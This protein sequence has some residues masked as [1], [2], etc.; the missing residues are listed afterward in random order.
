V[1]EAEFQEPVVNVLRV[2]FEDASTCEVEEAARD[3]ARHR[4]ERFGDGQPENDQGREDRHPGRQRR[5]AAERE[6][7]EAET[8]GGRARVA[9][10]RA[11]RVEV[12]REE[13]EE[14]AAENERDE[15]DV[16]LPDEHGD[17][18]ETDRGAVSY[19]HLTLPTIYSV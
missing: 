11:R 1:V 4:H 14:R 12:V 5:S 19:T 17:A 2:R 7:R 16:E 18:R 13:T 9:E 15:C 3:A 8:D 10:E 6:A